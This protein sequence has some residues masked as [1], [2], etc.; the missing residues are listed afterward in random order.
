MQAASSQ[1]IFPELGREDW[2]GEEGDGEGEDGGKKG[3]KGG[4]SEKIGL[5]GRE[6]REDWEKRGRERGWRD[7]N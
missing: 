5:R 4:R 3:R 6:G 2:E 1:C 7:H